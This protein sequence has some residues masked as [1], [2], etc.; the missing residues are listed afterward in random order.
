MC[1][2]IMIM[3]KQYA[4]ILFE[5]FVTSSLDS[6]PLSFV[7]GPLFPLYY[8]NLGMDLAAPDGDISVR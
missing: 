2:L 5:V 7:L 4:L 8:G 3:G 6:N 1:C